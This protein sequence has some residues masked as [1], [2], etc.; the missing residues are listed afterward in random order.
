MSLEHLQ[1][2]AVFNLHLMSKFNKYLKI[3]KHENKY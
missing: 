3:S 1:Q 2:I